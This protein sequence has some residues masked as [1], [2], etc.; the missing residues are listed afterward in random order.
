MDSV[1][2]DLFGKQV[3]AVLLDGSVGFERDSFVEALGRP[4]ARRIYEAMGE[5]FA[6]MGQEGINA[7]IASGK[8]H[9][10]C[11]VVLADKDAPHELRAYAKAWTSAYTLL[12]GER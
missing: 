3:T 7:L 5:A 10:L 8:E 9:L 2:V 11:Q 4:R 12:K 6:F 1:K